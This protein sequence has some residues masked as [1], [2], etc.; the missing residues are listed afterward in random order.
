MRR[1]PD[2]RTAASCEGCGAAITHGH[3]IEHFDALPGEPVY[4]WLCADCERRT[5]G[6]GA[7]ALPISPRE[8]Q[9]VAKDKP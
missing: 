1:G 8:H 3:R 5:G 6:P 4:T 9:L 2:R 7:D